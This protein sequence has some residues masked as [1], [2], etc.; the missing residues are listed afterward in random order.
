MASERVRRFFQTE[1]I[2][3]SAFNNLF[4]AA[5]EA[6]TA[7]SKAEADRIARAENKRRWEA[8][9]GLQRDEAGLRRTQTE[10]SMAV[11]RLAT[12]DWL[13]KLSQEDH[14]RYEAL[15]R[16]PDF[17]RLFPEMLAPAAQSAAPTATGLGGAPFAPQLPMAPSGPAQQAPDPFAGFDAQQALRAPTAAPGSQAQTP[18]APP[19]GQPPA[20]ILAQVEAE[21]TRLQAPDIMRPAAPP[22]PAAPSPA[23]QLLKRG[24]TLQ[25][26]GMQTGLV[27]STRSTLK[28]LDEPGGLDGA[29]IEIGK[30]ADAERTKYPDKK[31]EID[32]WE[33]DTRAAAKKAWDLQLDILKKK[34]EQERYLASVQHSTWRP[35]TEDDLRSAAHR[36]DRTAYDTYRRQKGLPK[37]TEQQWTDAMSEAVA[38]L[39]PKVEGGRL[40]GEKADTMEQSKL[41][42]ESYYLGQTIEGAQELAKQR[43]VPL[44]VIKAEG[45]RYYDKLYAGGKAPGQRDAE[46]MKKALLQRMASLDRKQMGRKQREAEQ[47]KMVDE[48]DVLFGDLPDAELQRIKYP[49]SGDPTSALAVRMASKILREREEKKRPPAPP[50]PPA[51]QEPERRPDPEHPFFNL[52]KMIDDIR[53]DVR[54]KKPMEKK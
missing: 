31:P 12:S 51:E 14:Y 24:R 9:F 52:G 47:A 16:S 50:A 4:G 48:F 45:M 15:I 21:R 43:G 10:Q 33:R 7:Y 38:Y 19:P 11:Q 13:S 17:G 25:T 2:V 42:E 36:K 8:E 26:A 5:N 20:D 32:K 40:Q 29:Y 18:Q 34:R 3:A 35:P 1:A 37:S 44:G 28:A 23:E 53:S 22:A 54:G 27:G 30:T 46:M 39:S 49:K 41:D 6:A